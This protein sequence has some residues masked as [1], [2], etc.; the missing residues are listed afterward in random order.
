MKLLKVTVRSLIIM[1][2][3]TNSNISTTSRLLIASKS[4]WMTR[5]YT[6]RLPR[7]LRFLSQTNNSKPANKCN[8]EI[9]QTATKTWASIL[10]LI[11]AI[12]KTRVSWACSW[13]NNNQLA[14]AV[15]KRPATTGLVMIPQKSDFSRWVEA[16][17][18]QLWIYCLELG[19]KGWQRT[20]SRAS[21]PTYMM[22]YAHSKRSSF[23]RRI[24]KRN[25]KALI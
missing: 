19:P 11:R 25:Q 3:G 8:Q 22:F 4:C 17:H 9:V 14:L 10:C 6:R 18:K 7:V 5:T 21:T 16:T 20:I 24:L 2:W 13:I 23:R 15:L 1:F 12:S